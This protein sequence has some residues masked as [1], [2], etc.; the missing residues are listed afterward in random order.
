MNPKNKDTIW[1]FVKLD[2]MPQENEKAELYTAN[3]FLCLFPLNPP[4]VYQHK[5]HFPEK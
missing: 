4:F 2:P 5:L 1:T 3:Q